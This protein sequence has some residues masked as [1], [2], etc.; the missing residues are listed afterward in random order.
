MSEV[1]LRPITIRRYASEGMTKEMIAAKLD[2]Y[3]SEFEEILKNDKGVKKAYDLGLIDAKRQIHRRLWESQ[4][5]GLLLLL[6]RMQLKM[7]DPVLEQLT[8]DTLKVILSK[9]DSKTKK[10]LAKILGT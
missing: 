6:A 8:G 1:S 10:T 7:D 2:L 3:E 9:A 5:R 4:D